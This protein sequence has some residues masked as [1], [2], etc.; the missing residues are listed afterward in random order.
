[1]PIYTA[2]VA[3][4]FFAG[5]GL[6]GFSG[7]VSEAMIFIG[8]FPVFKTV[9][10]ISTLGILLNA[11]YFLWAFQRMFF[12]PANEKYNDLPEINN[13]E[14]FTVIPLAVITLI[15]GIY[16]KINKNNNS[17]NYADIYEKNSFI[18]QAD[19]IKDVKVVSKNNVLI[20]MQK[21]KDKKNEKSKLYYFI[22]Y[23]FN[24]KEII[25]I[26]KN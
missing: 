18:E 19:I 24:K 9:V 13:R 11:A 23:D 1:M 10:I 16:S 26:I 21:L 8:A 17:M 15:L 22:I 25:D 14:L 2:F 20:K 12:G 4:A 5:L 7:F 6:P 3:I